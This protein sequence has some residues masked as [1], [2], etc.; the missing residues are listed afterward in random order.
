MVTLF[1]MYGLFLYLL[2]HVIYAVDS[3]LILKT[4]LF[5]QDLLYSQIAST[6]IVSFGTGFYVQ[7]GAGLAI[8]GLGIFDL[9]KFINKN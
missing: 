4:F 5:D 3:L 6:D 7:F 2:T 9:I 1:T 8:L